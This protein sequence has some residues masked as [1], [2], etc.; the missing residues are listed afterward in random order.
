[1][2]WAAFFER[3]V[4]PI[5]ANFTAP[6]PLA[7]WALAG[8][9]VIAGLATFALVSFPR[10]LAGF[11]PIGM[12]VFGA[13]NV[14]QGRNAAETGTS[15]V[16]EGIV[17]SMR[18]EKTVSD[19]TSTGYTTRYSYILEVELAKAGPLTAEGLTLQDAEGPVRL[20]TTETIYESLSEGDELVGVSLPTGTHFVHFRVLDDGTVVR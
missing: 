13:V 10:N 17:K 4:T 9:A 1:M 5:L 11:I 20:T 7:I 18:V 19:S 15:Q 12:V 8:V 3:E 14:L 6:V 16:R 2:D